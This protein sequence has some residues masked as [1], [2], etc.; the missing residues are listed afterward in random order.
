M[1]K[2]LKPFA[3]N[4]LCKLNCKRQHRS[5]PTAGTDVDRKWC[6]LPHVEKLRPRRTRAETMTPVGMSVTNRRDQPALVRI[7]FEDTGFKQKAKDSSFSSH[8]TKSLI[9]V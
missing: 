4:N 8:Q 5:G 7:I 1:G 6:A 3:C 9:A 2:V